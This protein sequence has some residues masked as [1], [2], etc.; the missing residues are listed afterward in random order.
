MQYVE[1]AKKAIEGF[2][3]LEIS[4]VPRAQNNKADALS[5]L[6][7]AGSLNPD[8]PVIMLEIPSPSVG[9]A[10]TELFHIEEKIEWFT[11]M[12][13]YLTTKQLPGDPAEARKITRAAP[14]YTLIGRELYRRGFAHPLLKCVGAEKAAEMLAEVHEGICGSNQGANT[15]AMRVLRAGFY[16][17]TM[18]QDSTELTKKCQKCQYHAKVAQQ[19]PTTLQT[20]SSPWPFDS[21]AA[22]AFIVGQ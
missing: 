19:P 21:S 12:V 9:T 14:K 2:M 10:S 5:K 11:P 15:L 6:A 3:S 16:W 20:L 13:T 22:S 1:E 4:H 8:Q 17:P 18:R 7:V